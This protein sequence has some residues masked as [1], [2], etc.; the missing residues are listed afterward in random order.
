MTSALA[1]QPQ[2]PN[3][4]IDSLRLQLAAELAPARW[5]K[6]LTRFSKLIR[7]GAI[8]ADS[9]SQAKPA[10]DLK[11]LL[12]AVSNCP[13][14]I[15]TLCELLRAKRNNK[16]F[17]QALQP[18]LY[19]AL[20]LLAT[21]LVTSGMAWI[22][23]TITMGLEW[24]D[25]R[26]GRADNLISRLFQS[27]WIR[28]VATAYLVGWLVLVAL[29]LR[30]LGAPLTR[31]SLAI[32]LPVVGKLVR[33][34][35]FRDMTSTYSVFLASG[36]N[37]EQAAQALAECYQG[38]L[39]AIPARGLLQRIRAGQPIEQAIWNSVLCDEFLGPASRSLQRSEEQT[40]SGLQSLSSL[41]NQLFEQR[42]SALSQVANRVGLLLVLCMYMRI[43]VDVILEVQ[44]IDGSLSQFFEFQ[45]ASEN[46]FLLLPLAVV[47]FVF[48]NS[49]FYP[50]RSGMRSGVT[51]IIKLFAATCLAIALIGLALRLTLADLIYLIPLSMA[52]MAMRANKRLVNRFAA[53]SALMF[54]INRP[55]MPEF[56][57]KNLIDENSGQVRH[58]VRK[59]SGLMGRGVPFETA[60][61][62][63]RL[64]TDHHERWLVA[65][66]S[67]FGNLPESQSILSLCSPWSDAFTRLFQ[68][69]NVLKWM[70]F[71]S[72]VCVLFELVASWTWIRLMSEFGVSDLG[73][74]RVL[75]QNLVF[76]RS[77]SRLSEFIFLEITDPWTS[78][79]GMMILCIPLIP[80]L[81]VLL[82]NLF[83]FPFLKRRLLD[84][85]LTPVYRAWTLRGISEILKSDSRIVH[86][87]RESSQIHPLRMVRSKLA[88]IAKNVEVGL[89]IQDA[90]ARSGMIR[91]S[92]RGL[93]MLAKDPSQLAWTLRQIAERNFFRWMEWYS[94]CIDM[95]ALLL[96]L[97]TAT[98]VGAFAFVQFQFLARIIFKEI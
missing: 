24:Y 81:F 94:M 71:V 43:A 69:L 79:W 34:S 62:R 25:W 58:R 87:L 98:F 27:Q 67:R 92:Q 42:M 28:A 3:R 75:Q 66:L 18:L 60:I 68:R 48:L 63:S 86:V 51:S 56:I 39:L 17:L 76:S 38:S 49:M 5:K 95:A 73:A 29:I 83:P 55:G 21:F 53:T 65:I 33:W 59:F 72:F 40:S 93:L 12:L 97:L 44:G 80:F 54:G 15:E 31:L 37:A 36:G 23:S 41:A 13:A 82:P 78:N 4:E 70:V 91:R 35:M 30:F 45:G 46:W 96:M 50:K 85:F 20:L 11:N 64:V 14:P 26:R 84:L 19:P 61:T 74:I 6:S 16:T 47:N 57:A 90:F 7:A 89:S 2:S 32:E 52:V 1:P 88:L 77:L 22:G 10:R 8:W 9:V